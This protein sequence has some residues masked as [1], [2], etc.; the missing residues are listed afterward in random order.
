MILV[1]TSYNIREY[2]GRNMPMELIRAYPKIYLNRRHACSF[3]FPKNYGQFIQDFFSQ[4]FASRKIST[5]RYRNPLNL[6]FSDNL[7]N[8]SQ[9]AES[10]PS[11]DINDGNGSFIYITKSLINSFGT[12]LYDFLFI[13]FRR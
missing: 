9:F 12:Q 7:Y 2:S 5:C 3:P 6:R 8:S 13:R 1:K 4:G 10:F 11:R